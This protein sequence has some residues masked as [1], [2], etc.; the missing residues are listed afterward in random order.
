MNR[1]DFLLASGAAAL[2]SSLG[3]AQAAELAAPLTLFAP[4]LLN[5]APTSIQVLCPI[6]QPATG[7]VEYGPDEKLGQRANGADAGLLPYSERLL[8]FELTGLRPGQTC[9]YRVCASPI[10]FKSAYSIQRGQEISTP[11]RSFKT[12]NPGAETGSF[13]VW[14]DTHETQATIK[15]LCASLRASPT[16]FLMWNGDITNNIPTEK[17]IFEQ[18]LT[19]AGEA[20]ADSTPLF[21]TRGNHDVRGRYARDLASTIA[22]PGGKYFYSFRQGPLGVIVMDTGEDKP[23]DL[24]VYAGLGGFS[25]Y[26]SIQ[27]KWLA[28]AIQ[29]PAFKSAPIRIAFLH[30]P[31]VWEK[32]VPASWPSVWGAG[33]K[34]WICED[35]MAKWHDLLVQAGIKV[36]ISGHTHSHAYFPPN[37]RRPYG[38]LIGGGPKPNIATAITAQADARSLRLTT[39]NL[40]GQI[41]M[42]QE[43]PA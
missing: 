33:I 5:P 12:L 38:Q 23:D 40:Q 13:T 11:I 17:V 16:D 8:R 27:Q 42:E 24:A 7:H 19:P 22:G 4:I 21:L 14:N 34:G 43:F 1:R 31:L 25:E 35:G 15:A 18:F 20:F 39:R 9:F 26:R 32:E 2:G 41:L 29:E 3:E 36:V 37:A 30:I 10:Q 28:S 6:N